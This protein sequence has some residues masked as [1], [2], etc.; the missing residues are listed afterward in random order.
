MS[1]ILSTIMSAYTGALAWCGKVFGS[2]MA[3]VAGVCAKLGLKILSINWIKTIYE[4]LKKILSVIKKTVFNAKF[5]TFMKYLL[6]VAIFALAVVQTVFVAIGFFENMS[7]VI[8]AF[9]NLE[10][11]TI[12]GALLISGGFAYSLI[13]CVRFVLKVFHKRIDLH[14]VGTLLLTYVIVLCYH[15]LISNNL[16]GIVLEKVTLIDVIGIV[17]AVYAFFA[18]FDGECSVSV[19][20]ALSVGLGLALLFVFFKDGAFFDFLHYEL[21]G[22][23]AFSVK[24]FN[25]YR[26]IDAFQNSSAV[27]GGEGLLITWCGELALTNVFLKSILIT[28][29]LFVIFGCSILPYLFLSAA[30]EMVIALIS[31]RVKQYVH[32][33]RS[34]TIM[35]FAFLYAVLALCASWGIALLFGRTTDLLI[36]VSVNTGGAILTL[37]GIVLMAIV[38]AAARKLITDKPYAKMKKIGLK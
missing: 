16:S 6:S 17:T 24:D 11:K 21:I 20:G 13:W 32:L 30:A 7:V 36:F 35:G 22:E 23:G 15:N 1:A 12:C 8:E 38:L 3:K 34:L 27:Y 18:L 2:L 9:Q 37:I 25:A 4:Y 19:F 14:F 29:N 5:V 10:W 33:N 31:D 26:F 28:L